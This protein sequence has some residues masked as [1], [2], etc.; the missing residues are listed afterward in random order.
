M[1]GATLMAQEP[2][3]RNLHPIPVFKTVVF[4]THLSQLITLKLYQPKALYDPSSIRRV[5]R[6]VNEWDIVLVS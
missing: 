6:V 2:G 4:A 3:T 5:V 1:T